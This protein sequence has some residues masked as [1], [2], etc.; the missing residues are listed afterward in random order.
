MLTSVRRGQ[1]RALAEGRVNADLARTQQ[2][3]KTLERWMV[4][5]GPEGDIG[6][7]F[8]AMKVIFKNAGA[9]NGATI[10]EEIEDLLDEY[11]MLAVPPQYKQDESYWRQLMRKVAENRHHDIRWLLEVPKVFANITGLPIETFEVD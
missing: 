3:E 4:E 6:G 9:N 10:E 5:A 8:R 1:V 7:L 2:V 11:F